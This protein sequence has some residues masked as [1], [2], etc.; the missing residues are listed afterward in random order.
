M[1][2]KYFALILLISIALLQLGCR[3]GDAETQKPAPGFVYLN[4]QGHF[5]LDGQEWFPLMINYKVGW[6]REGDYVCVVPADYYENFSL[7]RGPQT[8]SDSYRLANHLRLMAEEMGANAVR[9]CMNTVVPSAQGYYFETGGEQA[10]LI[11]DSSAIFRAIDRMLQPLQELNMKAMLLIKQPVDA[12]LTQFVAALLRHEAGN[13][14]IWAWDFMNEPLYFDSVPYRPK[15][16]AFAIVDA[17]RKMVREYAP[18]HL[19]TIG[20]AEPLEVFSWDPSMM[21]VDFVQIH[22]YH[23]LRVGSEMYWYGRYCHKPW[24]VGETSLPADN[25]SVPYEWQQI[26][27]RESFQ[28]AVDNGAIGYG[29]WEFQDC[30]WDTAFEA[31]HSGLL[32]CDGCWHGM[33]NTGP[34]PALTDFATLKNFQRHKSQRPVNYQNMLGYRN[35]K[36]CGRVVDAKT[37]HPIEG[38][39]IRGWNNDWSV[40][41]NTFSMADGNFTLYSNDYCQHLSVSAPG[42]TLSQFDLDDVSYAPQLSAASLPNRTLEYQQIS[43]VPFLVDTT[44]MLTFQPDL[45]EHCLTHADL[46]DVPLRKVR[47]KFS[48]RWWI[49]H[50]FRHE[51]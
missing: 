51:P 23:P 39:V 2:K 8:W 50:L 43:Q 36:L 19:F 41:V 49:R 13:S 44:S 15:K 16:E 47:Y 9:I 7:Q 10:Y 32:H 25:D 24:M 37:G 21:P 38:A 12:E 20:F 29:W 30:G 3:G 42:M 31:R 34:K 33:E 45:F 48:L 14:A 6:V 11:A 46:G 27:L 28:C 4:S 5:E 26:F 1:I 17:W 40:G 35:I 18:H 22:T